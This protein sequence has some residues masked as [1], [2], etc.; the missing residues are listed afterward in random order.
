MR[1]HVVFFFRVWK[2]RDG[3]D[4]HIGSGSRVEYM[5]HQGKG[6]E[7]GLRLPTTIGSCQSGC[8][9]DGMGAGGTSVKK[10]LAVRL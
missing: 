3:D 6:Y 2:K 7:N 1:V 10:S 5:Y 8:R 9:I 4:V